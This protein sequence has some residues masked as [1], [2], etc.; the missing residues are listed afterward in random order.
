MVWA[1]ETSKPTHSDTPPPTKPHLP[2]LPTVPPIKGKH[3]HIQGS[4]GC[5]HSNYDI[6]LH[7]HTH[8][9]RERERERYRHRHI[10][11]YYPSL[12]SIAV[13]KH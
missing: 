4:R 10:D 3:S 8:R 12:F 6:D 9:E 2:I 5:S 13:I 7:I 1:F 11:T